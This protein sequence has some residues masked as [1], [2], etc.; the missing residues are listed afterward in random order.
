MSCRSLPPL[1]S[2]SAM[3]ARTSPVAIRGSHRS[4]C[5]GV[6]CRASSRATTL[7]PPTAPARLIQ[8]RASSSVTSAKQ[9]VETADSLHRAGTASPKT[10]ISFIW[11]ISAAGYSCARSS[12]PAWGRTSRSTQCATASTIACSSS[13]RSRAVIGSAVDGV[14][15]ELGLQQRQRGLLLVDD[16]L[17]LTVARDVGGPL[18]HELARLGGLGGARRLLR[19]GRRDGLPGT[20]RGALDHG[21]DPPADAEQ[22]V[23]RLTDDVLVEVVA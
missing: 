12:R 6:P 14:G 11:S 21:V 23:E 19:L 20:G 1:G 5:S 4:C 16:G 22:L 17:G 13:G 9:R 7:W 15:A 3:A 2:V 8:P 10:P 18:G